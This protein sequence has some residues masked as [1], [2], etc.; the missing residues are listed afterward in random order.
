MS[1]RPPQALAAGPQPPR[2]ARLARRALDLARARWV[3]RG[4]TL[5]ARVAVTGWLDLRCEGDVTIGERCTFGGGPVP[6]QLH[7]GPG[8]SLVIGPGCVFNYGVAIQATHRI[9]IGEGCMVASY[10]VLDDVTRDRV[11]P[12]V[13]G[14]GVWIAHGAVVLP[15]V[16]VGAGSVIAAR[17]VV[18]RDMPEQT[19]AIGNPARVMPLRLVD[20]G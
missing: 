19:L 15:G 6:S 12:I 7:C 14:D 4:C 5:G 10:V 3:L 1:E 11:G 20:R 8:G 17:A 9:E 16:T 18:A 13:I 2:L